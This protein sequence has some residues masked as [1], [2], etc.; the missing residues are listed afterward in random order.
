[1]SMLE[2][3]ENSEK[4]LDEYLDTVSADEFLALY[5]EC[6]SYEGLTVDQWLGSRSQGF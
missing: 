3:F 6:E 2:I 4:L 5:D 1:M